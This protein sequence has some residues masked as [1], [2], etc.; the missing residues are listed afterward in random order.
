MDSLSQLRNKQIV[1]LGLGLTGMSFVRFLSAHQFVFAVNDSR[2]D[3][4]EEEIFSRQYPEATLVQGHWDQSLIER[5]EILLVSPGIDLESSGINQSISPS[6][7]VWGD[8]ELYCRLTQTPTVAVTGSNGKSTVVSL[9]D[10]IGKQLGHSTQLG[11][12]VGVPVLDTIDEQPELLIL[13]LSSFQLETM[14]SMDAVA[15]AML[16]LSDDHLDRHHDMNNYGAIKQRIYQQCRTAIYNRDDEATI[17]TAS[18]SILSHS[19]PAVVTSIG[20]DKP[21]MGEFGLDNCK[22][23]IWL[24]YGVSPLISIRDLPI[25]GMHNALNC[26]TA[27][28]IGQSVGWP[29]KEMVKVL[30][31]FET[32]PHRCQPVKSADGILWIN[33]SKATNVGATIAAINGLASTINDSQRLI[34]I[35]GGEG[36]GADFTPLVPPL[37]EWVD[38]L[39][40]LGKDGQ[41]IAALHDNSINV[42]DLR[43]AVAKAKEL[44]RSGDIVLLSPACAS[45]DMF[46]NFSERGEV[47]VREVLAV[48]EVRHDS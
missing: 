45:I 10:H 23:E 31:S 34:L 48:N 19:E 20:S 1:V 4:V 13:E 40:T 35:A 30:T 14:T 5:A 2:D 7:Q 24:F 39:I 26:L 32:L 12:N 8:V 16:N 43:L 17:P 46:K 21:A 3:I 18:R 37:T 29:I 22:D 6:C 27:L 41:K 28:A 44:A 42:A 15:G 11:G 47:F 9:V 36:K 38:S 33:D 25:A